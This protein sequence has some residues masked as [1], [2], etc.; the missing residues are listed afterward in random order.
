MSFSE[1]YFFT[2]E[3][4]ENAENGRTIGQRRQLLFPVHHSTQVV[5]SAPSASAAVKK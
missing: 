2:A 4:A 3:A 1:R 5:V